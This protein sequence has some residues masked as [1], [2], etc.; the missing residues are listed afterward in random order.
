M[1]IYISELPVHIDVI[2]KEME[3][4]ISLSPQALDELSAGWIRKIQQQ[5]LARWGKEQSENQQR[6]V[7]MLL[8]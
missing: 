3:K 8:L 2:N 5:I 4:Q 7:F 1:E 6:I